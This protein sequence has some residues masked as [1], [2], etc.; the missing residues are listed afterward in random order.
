MSDTY[1]AAREAKE[2]ASVLND[3]IQTWTNS[4]KRNGYLEKVKKMAAAYHGV[5]FE[6]F[7]DSHEISFGGEQGELVKLPVNHIKNLADHIVTMITSQRPAFQPRAVNT[8]YASVIQTELAGGLLDYYLRE[9]RLETYLKK[10][11]DYGVILSTGYIKMDWNATAG[12]VYDVDEETGFNIY[13]GDV[14]FSNLSPFDVVFDGT[15]EWEKQEWILVRTFVNKYN[16][17]AK[18]PEHAEK[19]KQIN[20]D[21]EMHNTGIMTLGFDDTSFIPVYEFF[22]LR[23][24]SMPNGRYMLFAGIDIVMDDGPMPYDRLPVYRI[25]PGEI[26]GT[27]FGYTPLFDILPLQEAINTLYST[28]LTN[29]HA[30]GVQNIWVPQGANIKVSQLAGGLNIIEGNPQAGK[31]EP[32]NLTATPGELFNFLQILEKTAETISG[33]NSVARGNPPPN[34]QSGTALALMQ[35]MTLQFMTGLQGQYIRMLEDVGT[36]LLLMLKT[37][38]AT[39]RVAAITGKNNRTLLKSFKGDDLSNINRVVVDVGNALASTTAGRLEMAEH[40]LQMGLLKNPQQYLTLIHTGNLDTMTQGEDKELILMR[41]ENEK[42]M[43]GESVKAIA[44]DDHRM[45]IIEHKAILSDPELRKDQALVKRVL[46]HIQEHINALRES[47][48]NLLQLLN[49]QPLGPEGGSPIGKQPPMGEEAMQNA[50]EGGAQAALSTQPLENLP[51]M[52]AIPSP[53]APF[54]NLPTN[55]AEMI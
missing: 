12:E 44:I 11:V 2:T 7:N 28:I 32:L 51:G 48:P 21:R 1:F 20:I 40:L 30:F 3:K 16:L 25:V 14:E 31:P 4:L 42:L 53:P 24:E 6:D 38:A 54:N 19:L 27:P 41:G 39:P 52:P 46:D 47:D 37:F 55:P 29:Q 5:F 17:A 22:H 15:V 9:K 43:A 8:D 13:E 45:H 18:Y 23:T 35:S 34:L 33:V 26:L 10:A 49:Q 36:G 50:E